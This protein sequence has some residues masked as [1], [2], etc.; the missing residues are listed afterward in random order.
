VWIEKF[1][2]RGSETR[3]GAH[4]LPTLDRRIPLDV[5]VRGSATPIWN[6]GLVSQESGPALY[7]SSS[8]PNPFRNEASFLRSLLYDYRQGTKTNLGQMGSTKR[9]KVAISEA[10]LNVQS[11]CWLGVSCRVGLCRPRPHCAFFLATLFDRPAQSTP[12]LRE[13]K[14]SRNISAAAAGLSTKRGGA[15]EP[16]MFRTSRKSPEGKHREVIFITALAGVMI[17]AQMSLSVD[18]ICGS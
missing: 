4:K 6:C 3:E 17:I 14:L 11:S 9:L 10:E 13:T 7:L 18:Q 1:A 8:P 15:L 5:N 16:E 12:L 2:L